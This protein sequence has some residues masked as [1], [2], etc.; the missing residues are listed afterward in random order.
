MMAR[1]VSLECMSSGQNTQGKLNLRGAT[2]LKSTQVR[3][4]SFESGREA[5]LH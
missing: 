3:W 5:G 2:R 4:F 1:Q